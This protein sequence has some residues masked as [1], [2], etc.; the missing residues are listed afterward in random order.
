MMGP[1]GQ[2]LTVLGDL[3]L[4]AGQGR[5]DRADPDV[6]GGVGGD[7]RGG[8]G[9]AVDLQDLD[10]DGREEGQEVGTDGR[11]TGQGVAQLVQAEPVAD[12][13]EHQL[14]E[15]RVLD[16]DLQRWGA[17][18][19]LCPDLLLAH[20]DGLERQRPLA[21]VL[22]LVD[23]AHDAGVHLLPHPRHG[24]EDV[25]AGLLEGGQDLGDVLDEVDRSPGTDPH[26]VG[27]HPLGDVGQR[28]VRDPAVAGLDVQQV[29]DHRELVEQVPVRDHHALRRTGGA[30]GVDQR[31]GVVRVDP[32]PAVLELSVPGRQLLRALRQQIGVGDDVV[33][34][35]EVDAR[36]V[37]DHHHLQLPAARHERRPRSPG[38]RR[39]RRWR[40][41]RRSSRRCSGSAPRSGC[42]RPTPGCH[43][44]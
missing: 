43:P 28:Q 41:W 17:T 6:T 16:A 13:G 20:L 38:T 31:H 14:V 21:I 36:R 29:H 3:H 39:P 19:E 7:D 4:D 30:R 44:P 1:T 11:S 35:V 33:A 23:L 37:D 26:V 34:A 18:G 32:S 22:R 25:G 40:P 12:L 8:L 42:C 10:P 24:H 5:A 27:G 2:Q 9:H 15:Q